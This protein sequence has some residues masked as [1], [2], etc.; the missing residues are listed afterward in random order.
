MRVNKL[1]SILVGESYI[2]GS[3]PPCIKLV[4]MAVIS[5][6]GALIEQNMQGADCISQLN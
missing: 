4:A 2:S 1:L 3:V 6:Q 5:Q